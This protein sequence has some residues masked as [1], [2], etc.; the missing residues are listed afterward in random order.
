MDIIMLF[1]LREFQQ[2]L[3]MEKNPYTN[4]EIPLKLYF[5]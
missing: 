4:N 1:D 3:N 5:I 2:I